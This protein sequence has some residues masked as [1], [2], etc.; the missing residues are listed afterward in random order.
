MKMPFIKMIQLIELTKRAPS[1]G[2]SIEIS[3]ATHVYTLVG[4]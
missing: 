3:R 2:C 1:L 4:Q